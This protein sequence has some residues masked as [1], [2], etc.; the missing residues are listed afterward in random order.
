MYLCFASSNEY[1]KYTGVAVAS[2]LDNNQQT[3]ISGVIILSFGIEE[4]NQQKL[5]QVIRG[6]ERECLIIDAGN[7]MEEIC[8][9]NGITAFRGSLATY[10][11]AFIDDLVPNYVD[12]LLYIDTDTVTIGSLQELADC[13]LD[14]KVMAAVVDTSR[15]D[16]CYTWRELKGKP[17]GFAYH[18]CGVV[19]F[20]M[21][22]WRAKGCKKLIAEE[23]ASGRSF[24]YADQSLINNAIPQD[25]IQLMSYRFNYW[26]HMYPEKRELYEM[27]RGCFYTTDEVKDAIDRPVIVHYPGILGKAWFKESVSRRADLYARYLKLTPWKDEELESI[28]PQLD[29]RYRSK[30][31]MGKFKLA[32]FRWKT[33]A[34]SI[35]QSKLIERI[36]ALILKE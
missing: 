6:Y 25:W 26:G 12:R 32:M 13:S 33:T 1:A 21:M 5:T 7:R 4:E 11:R 24:K 15:Y 23:I 29:K 16:R 36:E 28:E 9:N 14:G 10:S 20:N 22:E 30:G 27:D 35:L 18:S 19:L 31:L 3:D 8:R 17:E 2:A 34:P